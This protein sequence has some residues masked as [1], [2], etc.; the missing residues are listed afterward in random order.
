MTEHGLLYCSKIQ[1]KADKRKFVQ[2]YTQQAEAPMQ[3]LYMDIKYR[4][5]NGVCR[6]ELV[7]MVLDV[8]SRKILGQLLW[9]R[10]SKEQVKWLLSRIIKK[11]PVKGIILRNDNASQ[12]IA[13]LVRDYII[14]TQVDQEF[15]HVATS[16]EN[17]F[18]E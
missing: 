13:Y 18:I 14:E 8:N 1:S 17:V 6:D 5:V 7:M 10:I 15:T 9:L 2:N 3:Q 16:E 12:C 11:H 4:Y